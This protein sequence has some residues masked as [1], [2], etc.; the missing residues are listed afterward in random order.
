[1]IMDSIQLYNHFYYPN[2]LHNKIAALSA[3]QD[4]LKYKISKIGTNYYYWINNT[5]YS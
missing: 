3:G 2:K 4:A 5:V 1:M